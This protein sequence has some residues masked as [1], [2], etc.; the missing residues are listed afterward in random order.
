MG[1]K[2]EGNYSD[3]GQG[4]PSNEAKETGPQS[5]TCNPN[6]VYEVVDKRKK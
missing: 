2:P 1:E 3:V 6:A 4:D 5:E